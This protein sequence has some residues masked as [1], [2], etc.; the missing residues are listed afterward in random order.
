MVTNRQERVPTSLTRGLVRAVANR[1][2]TYL[3]VEQFF[4]SLIAGLQV[5]THA[6]WG[7]LPSDWSPTGP[8]STLI[9]LMMCAVLEVL[10]V[11]IRHTRLWWDDRHWNARRF[12]DFQNDEIRPGM[13]IDVTTGQCVDMDVIPVTASAAQVHVDMSSWTGECRPFSIQSVAAPHADPPWSFTL[14]ENDPQQ[15]HLFRAV[16]NDQVIDHT[17]LLVNGSVLLSSPIRAFVVACGTQRKWSSSSSGPHPH[18]NDLDQRV[19]TWVMRPSLVWMVVMVGI[20]LGSTDAGWVPTLIRTV[21][22][23]NGIFPMSVQLWLD[24]ARTV[25]ARRAQRENLVTHVSP[26]HID[27]IPDHEDQEV[28]LVTDKTGTLT[29]NAFTCMCAWWTDKGQLHRFDR[30]CLPSGSMLHNMSQSVCRCADGSFETEEDRALYEFCGGISLSTDETVKHIPYDSEQAQSGVQYRRPDGSMYTVWKASLNSLKRISQISEI[31]L[32]LAHPDTSLRL[33]GIAIQEETTKHFELVAVVGFADPVL[34]DA[35][36]DLPVLAKRFDGVCIL[37]GDR[38]VTAEAVARQCGFSRFTSFNTTDAPRRLH[39]FAPEHCLLGYEMTP[40]GKRQIVQQLQ[41]DGKRVVCIGDGR[42]DDAMIAQADIGISL[43]NEG[44]EKDGK[45]V[46]LSKF[47]QLLPAVEYFRTCRR[48]NEAVALFTVWKSYL[49]TVWQWMCLLTHQPLLEWWVMMGFHVV[50]SGALMMAI[51]PQWFRHALR[52]RPGWLLMSMPFS[53]L[54]V[55]LTI[56]FGGIREIS[57]VFILA[58]ALLL[59]WVGVSKPK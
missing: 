45:D 22:A 27:Q 5:S 31:S 19:H 21:L 56:S 50:W 9:P 51:R 15:R 26:R 7:V 18:T 29:A 3:V 36:R 44:G 25:Q 4:F 48:A 33:L 14:L 35:T 30:S 37:T 24:I 1:I 38:R 52:L 17:S 43:S 57:P 46:I 6:R 2:Y 59:M 58:V 11:S 47:S 49:L 8:F 39:T 42:N 28:W 55:F 53:L 12:G 20:C 41:Q 10:F 34:S 40:E 32:A 13:V 16:L 54:V 23:V